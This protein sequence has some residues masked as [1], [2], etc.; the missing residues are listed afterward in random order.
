MN[1]GASIKAVL[2]VSSEPVKWKKKRLE[3]RHFEGEIVVFQAGDDESWYQSSGSV[4]EININWC[5][6]FQG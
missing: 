3:T 2:L 4:D 6:M 5:G 1:D